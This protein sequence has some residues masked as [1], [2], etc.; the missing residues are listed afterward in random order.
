MLQRDVVFCFA[1]SSR[2]SL[3]RQL[4][5]VYNSRDDDYRLAAVSGDG[6]VGPREKSR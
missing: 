3:A 6:K 1:T 2:V 5:W 4:S